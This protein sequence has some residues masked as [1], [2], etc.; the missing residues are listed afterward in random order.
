M[1]NTKK[2]FF[3]R[4]MQ[5]LLVAAMVLSV[6]MSYSERALA[7]EGEIPDYA[8][9][10]IEAPDEVSSLDE[11][12]VEGDSIYRGDLEV[13]DHVVF[14]EVISEETQETVYYLQFVADVSEDNRYFVGPMSIDDSYSDGTFYIAVYMIINDFELIAWDIKEITLKN[15]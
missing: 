13:G 14:V 10:T 7:F 6:S 8:T 1:D 9:L 4:M 11:F 12:I 2:G 3:K 15:N 5:L